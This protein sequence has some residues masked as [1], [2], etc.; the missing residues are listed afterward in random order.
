MIKIEDIIKPKKEVLEGRLQAVIQ[1]FKVDSEEDRIENNPEMLFS[2]TYPSNAIKN[3]IERVNDK[4]TYKT[5]KGSFILS[6]PR[7]SGKSHA[8]VTL[9]HLFQ[10]PEVAED[11]LKYWNIDFKET[12]TSRSV[13][14]SAQEADPDLLWKPIFRK[15]GREDLLKEVK[16]YPTTEIIE[17]LVEDKV[18]AVFLD[19]LGTWWESFDKEEDREVISKNEMFLLALSEVANDRNTQ[20]FVFV[21]SYG[22]ITGL[23]KTLNRTNPYREDMASS[24]DK[25]KIIF[26]R[27]LEKPRREIAEEKFREVVKAYI[28]EYRKPIIIDNLKRYEEEFVKSYP[29]HPQLLEVL[30]NIY[31]GARERQ[32]VRGEMRVLSST[33]ASFYDKTDVI[34][35][36]DLNER[37]FRGI[38]RELVNKFET[39]VRKRIKDIDYGKELLKVIL[40]HSLENRETYATESDIILGTLKPTYGM[41]LTQLSMGLENIFGKAHY[42]HK[43]NG[44]YTIKKVRNLIAL[45]ESERREIED[46]EVK[47]ELRDLVKKKIFENQAY[48]YELEKD[49]V[50]DDRKSIKFVITLK[51]Y[52]GEEQIKKEL[53]SFLRGRTYQNSIVFIV[54][55]NSGLLNDSHLIG[56]MK[57]IRAGKNLKNRIDEKAEKIDKI[58]DDEIKEA[59]SYIK[60][61]YG[62]WIKWIPKEKTHEVFLIKKRIEPDIHEIRE[63][64]RTDE[65]SLSEEILNEIKGNERGRKIGSLLQ[66]FKKMRKYPLL[67]DDNIF[68]KVLKNLNRE[69][70]IIRGDRGK[71]Y[72][73]TEPK[74]IKNEWEVIDIDFVTPPDIEDTEEEEEETEETEEEVPGGIGEKKVT[75]IVTKEAQGNSFRVVANKYEM[76]LNEDTLENVRKIKLDIDVEEISKDELLEFFEQFPKCDFIKFIKSE[77]EAEEEEEYG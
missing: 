18:F 38:D 8:L 23:D 11:W 41:S 68:Y 34:L 58:V 62:Y 66:D 15:T 2:S 13:I 28:K 30:G 12:K 39:D 5:A 48:I 20:L 14:I 47:D 3:V 44:H 67:S 74:E 55:K 60:D 29:F 42:L 65:S 52:G 7:G 77:I 21:T 35:L 46:S 4:L 72:W 24:G 40:M 25:E 6:G 59:V 49:E 53:E 9:Y 32:S 19:E 16:R 75:K 27:L 45:I 61:L 1:P 64:I 31:E 73:D 71:E 76:G 54:P 22:K 69:K 63:S 51:S 43:D 57:N 50:P 56:K 37:A 17:K 70:L 36:S 10:H 26:H 33:L